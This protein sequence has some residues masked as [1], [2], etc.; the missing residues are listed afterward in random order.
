MDVGATAPLVYHTYIGRNEIACVPGPNGYNNR[1]HYLENY[2]TRDTFEHELH[3]LIS[4]DV[5]L[6][7]YRTVTHDDAAVWYKV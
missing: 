6:S 5:T 4:Q 2:D 7:G 1:R 3:N